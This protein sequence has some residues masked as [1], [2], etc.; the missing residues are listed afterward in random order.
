[1]FEIKLNKKSVYLQ[2]GDITH[3]LEELE[4]K[5]LYSNEFINEDVKTLLEKMNPHYTFI[6]NE[7]LF[8]AYLC[9]IDE[10]LGKQL[11]NLLIAIMKEKVQKNIEKV[12]DVDSFPKYFSI[13]DS[14]LR[15]IIQKFMEKP[16][17]R[18]LELKDGI[19]RIRTIPNKEADI[20]ARSILIDCINPY[21]MKD[22]RRIRTLK[23]E[24][25]LAMKKLSVFEDKLHEAKKDLSVINNYLI[26]P[27]DRSQIQ[28]E[29]ELRQKL[30]GTS[31]LLDYT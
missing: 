21:I 26:N 12:V 24:Y 5:R 20:I 8:G 18:F 3:D 23:P 29:N 16:N 27:L 6:F 25:Q 30:Y 11:E 28:K 13:R 2:K 1:M 4:F 22:T 31:L 7:L 19:L 15:R 14:N 17:Y 9:S 10:K